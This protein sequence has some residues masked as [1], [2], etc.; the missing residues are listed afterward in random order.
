M[1]SEAEIRDSFAQQAGYCTQ[2]GA[3]F[4][5]LLCETLGKRLDRRTTV[6]RCVLDW[7]GDPGPFADGL[8]LRLC[9]GLHFLARSGAAPGLAR[10]YPPAPTPEAETLWAALIP[11]LADEGLAT[12]LD[13][14]P[15]TNEVGRSAVLMSGLLVI[16][17]RF[18][19]PIRLYE[20]GASA[21]L[22]LLLDRYCYELGGLKTGDPASGVKL[23]PEWK[24]PPPPSASVKVI[25][26]RGTDLNPARL[27]DEGARLLAYVWPDQPERLARLE[28][29]V[30]IAAANPP[31]VDRAGA[32]DW[33]EEKLALEPEAGVTRVVMHSVAFQYFDADS[34]QRVTAQIEATGERASATAPLAW[35]RYELEPK[36]QRPSL[37]LRTWPGGEELLAWTHP[38]GR[39]VQWLK[40]Q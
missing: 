29:A 5:A 6:G 40:D 16:A 35:L 31:Q 21:G 36:A 38:H 22:N 26:R 17:H 32:A 23:E 3:P 39:S 11:A 34:Q 33:I 2:L 30:A 1:A 8:A 14:A 12:W 25:G 4:T 13:H 27:P 19:L 15:Q 20:L 28:A 24:G 37:R 10:L 18:R 7:R 9:G